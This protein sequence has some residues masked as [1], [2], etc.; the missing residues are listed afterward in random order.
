MLP[1]SGMA[2]L[3]HTLSECYYHDDHDRVG[4]KDGDRHRIPEVHDLILGRVGRLRDMRYDDGS[5]ADVVECL[6]RLV[7]PELGQR[8]DETHTEYHDDDD[9]GLQCR[10][11]CLVPVLYQGQNHAPM[12]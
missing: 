10:A 5:V 9:R 2:G 11:E 6:D 3:F 1:V 4:Q 12:S 7:L 8:T